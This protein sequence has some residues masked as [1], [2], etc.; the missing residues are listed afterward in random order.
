[1]SQ[2]EAPALVGSGTFIPTCTFGGAAVGMVPGTQ[3]GTYQQIGKYIFFRIELVVSTIG[4][5]TGTISLGGLPFTAASDMNNGIAVS[6]FNLS[7]IVGQIIGMVSSGATSMRLFYLG[8]GNQ[9]ELTNANCQNG[10]VFRITGFY[11]I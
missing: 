4:S 10:V 7:S 3:T 6:V 2:I 1:M 8:T 9:T 5:S 11:S